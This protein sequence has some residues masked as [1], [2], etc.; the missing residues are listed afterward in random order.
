MRSGERDF[1]EM[2]FRA[3]SPSISAPQRGSKTIA[4]GKRAPRAPPWVAMSPTSSPSPP[5]AGGEGRAC[6]ADASERRRGEEGFHG[7]GSSGRVRNWEVEGSCVF[8]DWNE[9]LV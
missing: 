5:A 3:L 8:I 2:E 7:S 4:Q 6:H 1:P 9:E